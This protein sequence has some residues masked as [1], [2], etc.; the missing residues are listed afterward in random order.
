MTDSETVLDAY[1][2]PKELTIKEVKLHLKPGL[3]NGIMTSVRQKD[4]LYKNFSRVKDCQMKQK[5]HKEFKKYK[6]NINILT[7]ISR[8]NYYQRFF[9]EHKQNMP[10]TWEGIKAIINIRNISKKNM[11]CLN[12]KNKMVQETVLLF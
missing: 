8:T 1:A 4:K 11:N 3:T 7:R 5:L 6:N 9:Q 2:S 10:K 12:I